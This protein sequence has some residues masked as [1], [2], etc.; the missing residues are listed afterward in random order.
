MSPTAISVAVRGGALPVAPLAR[1]RE[2]ERAGEGEERA[3]YAAADTGEQHLGDLDR[4]QCRSLPEVVAGEEEREAVERALVLAD[5]ADEH[6]VAA[7]SVLRRR[8][9]GQP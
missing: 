5:P 1:R 3:A 7:G 8:E 2:H 4:V 6:L 9:L